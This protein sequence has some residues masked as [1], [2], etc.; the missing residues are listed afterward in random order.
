[1][2]TPKSISQHPVPEKYHKLLYIGETDQRGN[3]IDF[4]VPP[5]IVDSPRS[6]VEYRAIVLHEHIE[7]ETLPMTY[8]DP[9]CFMILR[10]TA[11]PYEVLVR[12]QL[13]ESGLSIHEEF[14]LDNFMRFAD[15]LYL[16]NPDIPFHWQWRIIMRTLHER[17][18]QD[19]NTAVV[20]TFENGGCVEHC[21]TAVLNLK[22]KIRRDIGEIPVIVRYDGRGEFALGIHHLHA[23]EFDRLQMEYNTLM[24]AR[25]KTSV[26]FV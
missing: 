12:K 25:H 24:H 20:F 18:V 19:Q 7:E 21:N 26:F 10:P 22:K 8:L 14:V 4:K 2:N 5:I 1:M 15:T 13:M 6:V 3:R 9:M 23:P 11:L 16:L 17:G